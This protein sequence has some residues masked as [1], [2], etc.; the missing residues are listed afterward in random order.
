MVY[1]I[2]NIYYYSILNYNIYFTFHFLFP[3]TYSHSQ[4]T[5]NREK[6]QLSINY[7]HI[8]FEFVV[9]NLV[10]FLSTAHKSIWLFVGWKTST[11]IA[12]S[13]SLTYFLSSGII[14]TSSSDSIVNI[15]FP[16]FTPV[17][18]E[19]SSGFFYS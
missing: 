1:N 2:F 17:E 5:K 4:L 12:D 14:W 11:I 15:E 13:Y 10:L 3:P 19:T 8:L 18:L 16:S 7:N 9:Y 6:Y